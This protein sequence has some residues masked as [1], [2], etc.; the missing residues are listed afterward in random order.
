MDQL[1][2]I[3]LA[4]ESKNVARKSSVLVLVLMGVQGFVVEHQHV[5]VLLKL[6]VIVLVI[7]MSYVVYHLRS[8]GLSRQYHQCRQYLDQQGVVELRCPIQ[9]GQRSV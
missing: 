6:D 5:R 3:L 4:L 7:M 2:Q 9:N 1:Y 8:L